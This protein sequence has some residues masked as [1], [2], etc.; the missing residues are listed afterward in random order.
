M[1]RK[2]K[3]GHVTGGRVFGY[4]NVDVT[5]PDGK[6]SHV[7]RRINEREAAIVRRIFELCAAGT[8]YTRIAKL[9]NHE[10]APCPRPQ[11]SRPA[12]WAPTSVHAILRRRLYRGEVVWNQTRKR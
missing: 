2:A 1:L 10:R 5:G 6:R 8:G 12:G 4:D 7:V 9:L 11:Q 3:A